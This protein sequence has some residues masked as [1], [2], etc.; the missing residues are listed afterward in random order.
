MK[1]GSKEDLWPVPY[2]PTK[3][4]FPSIVAYLFQNA[5]GAKS[6]QPILI[7]CNRH[8]LRLSSER[9]GELFHGLRNGLRRCF[10]R[11]PR[12]IVEKLLRQSFLCIECL[13]HK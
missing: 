10:V 6:V 13:S 9:R 4:N 3:S 12:R 8:K 7:L 2:C 11:S 1:F 5:I